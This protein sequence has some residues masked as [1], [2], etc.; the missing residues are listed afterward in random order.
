MAPPEVDPKR[1][2]R[3]NRPTADG[4]TRLDGQV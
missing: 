3:A 2:V 4:F 1:L